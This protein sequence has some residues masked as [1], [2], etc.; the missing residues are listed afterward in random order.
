MMLEVY[1]SLM[2][3]N[4]LLCVFAVLLLFDVFLNYIQS[5]MYMLINEKA[6]EI[7]I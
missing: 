5:F 2:Y 4:K 3:F 1:G 7:I 6:S